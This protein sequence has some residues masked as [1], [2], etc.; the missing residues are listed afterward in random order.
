MPHR[1]CP[2]NYLPSHSRL[3]RAPHRAVTTQPL[4]LEN[5]R[6]GLWHFSSWYS[7]MAWRFGGNFL[8]S[9]TSQGSL[10]A[11]CW[12]PDIWGCWFF[13]KAGSCPLATTL[14]LSAVFHLVNSFEYP[15]TLCN[16][17]MSRPS[18]VHIFTSCCVKIQ[19]P[20]SGISTLV[21]G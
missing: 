1:D 19:D 14:N 3:P 5:K 10:A 13:L 11:K 6:F 18:S 16:A 9:L 20:Y 21:P 4:C 8:P 7:Q 15:E 17:I 12:V 2:I